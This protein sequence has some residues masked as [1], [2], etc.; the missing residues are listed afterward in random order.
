MEEQHVIV[1]QVLDAKH[2][3]AA[4]DRFIEQY[5][6]FIK[7][8]TAKHL[9][10]DVM[11]G[12]DDELSI[13][14]FA[15]YESILSYEPHRGSFL[16]LAATAIRHR[17]IDHHRQ[18]R[19]HV[20]LLSYDQP[21]EDSESTLLDH[22]PHSK[23]HIQDI[24]LR[25]A[26]QAEIREFSEN[27]SD[28]QLSLSDVADNCPKQARTLHACME[29][30]DYA[31]QHP[32]LLEQMVRT[33]KLPITQ[34]TLATGVDRKVLERHRKYLLAVL[35]AYTNGFEIIRG[36]LYQMKRKEGSDK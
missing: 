15:F 17:L 18:Q 25:E 24:I 29:V 9:K 4:A 22:L 3:T 26:T 23:D 35:L 5:M 21:R 7:A 10:R 33:K 31:R 36:H 1:G 12:H 11:D 30:M 13:A 14:M 6:P 19:R 20:G 28:F 27:L 16:R 32:V 34:L 2:S 8:E